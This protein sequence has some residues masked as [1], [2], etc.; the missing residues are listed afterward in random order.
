MLAYK[1]IFLIILVP[2]FF[3]SLFDDGDSSSLDVREKQLIFFSKSF[4][5]GELVFLLW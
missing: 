5:T 4:S 2:T 3:P 1:P